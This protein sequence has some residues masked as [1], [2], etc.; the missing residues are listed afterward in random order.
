MVAIPWK[1]KSSYAHQNKNRDFHPDLTFSYLPFL[2]GCFALIALILTLRFLFATVIA[3]KINA[4]DF[5]FLFFVFD[6]DAAFLGLAVFDFDTTLFVDLTVFC[7][8]KCGVT[9]SIA[10]S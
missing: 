10:L 2:K 8:F 5:L 3:P 6:F 1:F 7:D 4:A 9:R